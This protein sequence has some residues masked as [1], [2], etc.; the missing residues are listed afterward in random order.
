M[1]KAL[2]QE[3]E[4]ISPRWGTGVDIRSTGGPWRGQQRRS[5]SEVFGHT[6]KEEVQGTSNGTVASTGMVTVTPSGTPKARISMSS[7]DRGREDYISQ[8]S[9]KSRPISEASPIKAEL[10][11][12]YNNGQQVSKS[13]LGSAS[14]PVGETTA[15]PVADTNGDGSDGKEIVFTTEEE[16]QAKKA[17]VKAMEAA[18]AKKK[19]RAEEEKA[20]REAEEELG[21]NPPVPIQRTSIKKKTEYIAV[22]PSAGE[23]K[24]SIKIGDFSSS[25]TDY[26][27]LS[28][29]SPQ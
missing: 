21:E 2:S 24:P 1:K 20:K 25:G 27:S 5:N 7:M 16:E 22:R 4:R 12:I 18:F 17:A 13:P 26:T 3:E 15:A 29:T 14:P 19:Q 11:S 23:A 28:E 8:F 9:E 10:E 6:V